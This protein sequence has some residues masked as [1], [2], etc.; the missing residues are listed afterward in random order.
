M[1]SFIYFLLAA[2]G[3]HTVG[4]EVIDIAQNPQKRQEIRMK[5]THAAATVYAE[6]SLAMQEFKRAALEKYANK[7]V[8]IAKVE[9]EETKHEKNDQE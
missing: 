5:A 6:A 9:V 1:L 7:K 8:V 4:K 2:A 3:L